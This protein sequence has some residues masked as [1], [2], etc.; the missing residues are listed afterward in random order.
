M[1]KVIVRIKGGLGNQLFSYSAA[2]RLSIANGAELVIDNVSGFA[3]DWKYQ[4]RYMLDK[5]NIQS[6]KATSGERLEPFAPCRR[7]L[8]RWISA[9]RPFSKREYLDQEGVDFDSRLLSLKVNGTLYLEG[10]WQSESYFKDVADVVRKDLSITPPSDS[11][12][13]NMA[14][15]ISSSQSVALHVRWFDTPGNV[16]GQNASLEYYKR[17]IQHFEGIIPNPKFFVF[18]DNP[19]A[20]RQ[21]LA[22][23]GERFV[24]VPHNQD[25]EMAYA[26]L[27]LMS[28]CRH[29]II[30]NST[31]SWW[32]AWLGVGKDKI[33]LVPDLKVNGATC[34]GFK[35][36]IPEGWK[37]I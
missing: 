10:Y 21:K 30:A 12:N 36:L 14:A 28:Q 1:N 32:G 2:R 7:R 33:V 20:A 8:F 13:L 15:D 16:A 37:S 26:D 17:A 4:R 35:G 5:F 22:L 25:H 18:S 9:G 27:W 6:R 34:W 24:F 29:F 3:R 19:E 23:A 31:F 11:L